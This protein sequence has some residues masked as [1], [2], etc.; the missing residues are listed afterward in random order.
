MKII[1]LYDSRQILYNNVDLSKLLNDQL[2]VEYCTLIGGQ[3][4]C[5]NV[6][7]SATTHNWHLNPHNQYYVFLDSKWNVDKSIF[8]QILIDLQQSNVAKIA[9]YTMFDLGEQ[10]KLLEKLANNDN[11]HDKLVLSPLKFYTF[12]PDNIINTIQNTIYN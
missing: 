3:C 7:N 6:G 12:Q 8:N 5:I 11:I 9:I 10:Q 2:A 4:K 1:R